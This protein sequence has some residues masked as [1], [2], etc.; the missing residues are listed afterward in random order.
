MHH[1]PSGLAYIA[2]TLESKGVDVVVWSQDMNH[3]PDNDLTTHLDKNKYD[4]IGLSFVGGYYQYNK[5]LSLSKAINRSKNRPLFVL[6]GHMAPPDPEYFRKVTGADV[7]VMG[8]G[9]RVI[10]D[11]ILGKREKS[12]G[13]ELIQD[14]DTIP[15][16]AYHL[17]PMEY[18]RLLRQPNCEKSDFVMSMISGRG[19]PFKC[20]F[21]YRLDKGFRP[22]D[23]D[24][25][26]E[27][28]K[29]LKANYGITYIEF[30]DELMMSSVSRMVDISKALGKLDIKWNCMGRLNYAKP[31]LLKLMKESGCVYVG[32]GVECFDNQVLKNM[33]KALT[34]KQ[35][36]NGINATLDAGITPG[37][38]VMWGNIG[39][40]VETLQKTVDFVLEYGNEKQIRTMRPVTPYPGS[41][42]FDFAKK[43]GLIKDV[44]DFYENKHINS[45]LLTCNFTDL[46]D[47]EFYS[48]LNHANKT[49]INNYYNKKREADITTTE[50][51][52]SGKTVD[53]RGYR[54]T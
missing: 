35:I 15:F 9:E 11:I 14:L 53:F 50:E 22:R 54:Q 32:Y 48:S 49:L 51:L 3:Y 21:C 46:S 29:L 31:D 26:V 10:E 44:E 12:Q 8:E 30:Q 19:C 40:N 20:N 17:F 45:D 4:V 7:I 1:F 36:I 42:L 27:E 5:L 24:G 38:F 13:R 23:I 52:Y 39:D 18:Y 28:I 2:S 47:K 37:T 16:P 6:G 43:E 25:V 41:P 34:E 33:S